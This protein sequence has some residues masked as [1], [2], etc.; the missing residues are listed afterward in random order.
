MKVTVKPPEP[1]VTVRPPAE[2]AA[3]PGTM[4]ADAEKPKVTVRVKQPVK[5]PAAQDVDEPKVTIRVRSKEE[6]SAEPAAPETSAGDTTVTVKV[7]APVKA[8]T[9]EETY[10]EQLDQPTRDLQEGVRMADLG[11]M[12]SALQAGADPNV[13]DEKGRPPLQYAAGLGL[14]PAV[15]LLVHFGAELNSRDPDGLTPLI[16][17][18][19]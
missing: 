3:P 16:L 18:S 14:A 2:A 17:A 6:A 9:Q 4:D 10:L 12:L 19:G 7:K 5:E 11:K 15:V 1:K 13:M 8:K